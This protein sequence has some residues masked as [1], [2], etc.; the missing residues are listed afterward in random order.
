MDQQEAIDIINEYIDY[1]AKIR[2]PGF[3]P[4]LLADVLDQ[5]LE[6]VVSYLEGEVERRRLVLNL[7][8]ECPECSQTV[9]LDARQNP[10]DVFGSWL[11]C[12]DQHEFRCSSHDVWLTFRPHPSLVDRLRGSMPTGQVPINPLDRVKKKNRQVALL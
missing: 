4:R 9:Y 6:R 2:S 3:S 12:P 10:D 8:I 11:A 5:D 7:R 1:S